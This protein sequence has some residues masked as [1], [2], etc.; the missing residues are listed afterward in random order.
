MQIVT[1]KKERSQKII[2]NRHPWIFS[3]AVKNVPSD[4]EPGDIVSVA[5]ETGKVFA[6]A[7]YNLHSDI[8]LRVI[9]WN[10]SE[11][12]DE[13]WFGGHI[14]NVAENK[15]CILGIKNLPE[16]KKNY[17]VVYAE[18]DDLPGLIID[19]YGPV[20]VMQL[21][22][23]FADRNRNLWVDIIK[24][25]F[26]PVAIYERSDV[27]VRKKEGLKD[28]PSGI[29]YGALPENFY[30]E[31]DGFKIKVD[32]TG[33][34]K[35]GYFLDLRTARKRIEYWCKVLDVKY[36]Q[37]YFAHTGSFNLYAVLAG[38]EK[39]EHIDSSQSA[40]DLALANAKIN[41]FAKNISVITADAFSRLEET[42]NETAE[43]VI[44]DPPSFVKERAKIKNAL[45]GYKRL[46]SLAMKKLK[47]SG[48]FF[49]FSCSSY[50]SEEDFQK[51]L[52]QAASVSVCEM[53]II[54]KIG[55]SPDHSYP[56]NF[57]EG[58]YL[59][60]WVLQKIS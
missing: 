10:P 6:Q 25:L 1:I 29:L 36:L 46:N 34:Q 55:A 16:N 31:E 21:Q 22:T 5:D 18:S 54:E 2:K 7:A 51:V 57:P 44:L 56:L 26:T 43:A 53:K 39:I 52:F 32:I 41:N 4:V 47:P 40:N 11:K 35:T 23:L 30:I 50:I 13:N 45:E 15:E 3:G 20:F 58:R 28:L 9:S 33:G 49:T 12:I 17:R 38:V 27:E 48:L 60:G 37:N 8:R 24:K 14:K 42:G 19:R 59:Q